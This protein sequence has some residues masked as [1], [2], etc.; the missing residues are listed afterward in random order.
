MNNIPINKKQKKDPKHLYDMFCADTTK[1]YHDYKKQNLDKLIVKITHIL[2]NLH[3]K[4]IHPL[5]DDLLDTTKAHFSSIVE[6]SDN[7]NTKYFIKIILKEDDLMKKMILDNRMLGEILKKNK[8]IELSHYTPE[9][10]DSGTSYLLYEFIQGRNIGSRYNDSSI[11]TV[12]ENDQII[13]IL[14]SIQY[15]DLSLIST[16]IESYGRD[17]FQFYISH[18]SYL[19][20]DDSVYKE[21]IDD[22]TIQ[23]I[24]KLSNDQKVLA[25]IDKNVHY[26]A[27]NDFRPANI[28]NAD[29]VMKIIDWDLYG[30]GVKF[31]DVA[32]FY[33][34]YY[35]DRTI[36][37]AYLNIWQNEKMTMEEQVLLFVWLTLESFHETNMV[38]HRLNDDPSNENLKIIKKNFYKRINKLVAFT[39]TLSKLLY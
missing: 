35:S 5:L 3:L 23:V 32:R 16:K 31:H 13:S 19:I 9:L 10:V 6:S 29:G 26:L 14:K 1:T 30:K 11:M 12:T 34:F 38:I 2:N 4:P 39:D 22:K 27:H 33:N 24:K 25:L 17:F 28:I 8:E 7:K 18:N 20:N 36:Q 37:K 21:Y 15:F